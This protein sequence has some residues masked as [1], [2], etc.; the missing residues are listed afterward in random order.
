MQFQ[1]R[2]LIINDNKIQ[3]YRDKFY[4]EL[5]NE[6]DFYSKEYKMPY[7]FE[8]WQDIVYQNGNTKQIKLCTILK[9]PKK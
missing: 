3:F 4:K 7:P 2:I 1:S 8:V 9:S 6:I 5:F